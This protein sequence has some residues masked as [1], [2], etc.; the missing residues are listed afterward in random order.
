MTAVIE[1]A[2]RESLARRKLP[3]KERVVLPVVAGGTLKPGV[4]LDCSA[5]LWD[6]MDE[7]DAAHRY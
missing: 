7:Y 2:L 5:D 3:K 6:L 4:N 1:D